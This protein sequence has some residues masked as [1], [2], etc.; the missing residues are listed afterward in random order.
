MNIIEQQ[1]ILQM[2]GVPLCKAGTSGYKTVK[3]IDNLIM[4][5]FEY[6]SDENLPREKKYDLYVRK[7]EA[8]RS[9]HEKIL[10]GETAIA[11]DCD[12]YTSTALELACIMGVPQRRLG[13]GLVISE[14]GLTMK[15]QNISADGT[16]GEP[17]HIDHNSDKS[18]DHAIGLFY[19]RNEW[20]TF[21]DTW[22]QSVPVSMVPV[23]SRHRLMQMS[24]VDEGFLW[25]RPHGW[26]IQ[27]R[28]ELG[29]PND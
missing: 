3:A 29:L 20:F 2:M 5:R 27:T 21:G 11:G 13:F 22:G 8:W 6:T 28:E 9:F 14:T 17:Y 26:K 18:I 12:D 15:F 1:R 25:R 10:N 19:H 16:L 4:E 24:F 7:L 23:K